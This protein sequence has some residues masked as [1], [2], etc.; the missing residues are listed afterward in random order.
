MTCPTPRQ[1]PRAR[2]QLPAQTLRT[3]AG[4]R[5]K[6]G[7][8]REHFRRARSRTPLPGHSCP[9]AAPSHVGLSQ[10][11]FELIKVTLINK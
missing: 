1:Q 10:F 3:R 4:R 7:Q 11:E 2:A 6:E 8:R 5:R 9:V